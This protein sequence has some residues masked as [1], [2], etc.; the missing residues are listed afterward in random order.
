MARQHVSG[1]D[2]AIVLVDHAVGFANLYRSHTV[3]ENINNV[4]ALAELAK[5]YSV[6]LVVTNGPDEAPTGPLYPALQQALGDT[7][8]V[9]RS[10]A[11]DCFDEPQ[12]AAA[13]EATGRR[14]LVMAGLMTEG[15]LLQTALTAVSL[16]YEV[17]AVLDASA[18]E[19]PETHQLAI[20]RMIQAGVIP[21]T[22][23]S[24]ASEYQRTWANEATAASFG[25]LI[26][27]HVG[28]FAAQGAL[29]ANVQKH[30][31]QPSS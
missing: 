12:F 25:K 28:P 5:V 16:G 17:F 26:F 8:T 21:T 22:W 27:D 3:G 1:E 30:A 15:C 24:I 14:R 23:L 19:T 18:G 11:F 29:T 20:Q 13:V 10:G 4:V 6:P 9:V 2:S 7:K 31:A